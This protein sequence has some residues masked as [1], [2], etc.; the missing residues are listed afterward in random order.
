MPKVPYFPF[1]NVDNVK[2]R[3]FEPGGTY[4]I[5]GKVPGVL[6]EVV[7]F[8]SLTGWRISEVLSLR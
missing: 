3:F 4:K 1:Y 7:R 5:V 2:M 8:L 6:S